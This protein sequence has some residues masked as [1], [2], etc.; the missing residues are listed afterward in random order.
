MIRIREQE[1]RL[2]TVPGKQVFGRLHIE[3]DGGERIRGECYSNHFRIVPEMSTFAGRALSLRF[4]ADVTGIPD[5]G[6]ID[7]GLTV[8]TEAGEFFIPVHVS[9]EETRLETSYGAIRTLS[10]FAEYAHSDPEEAFRLMRSD[11]FA[12]LIPEEDHALRALWRGFSKPPAAITA[13]EEFL[14]GAGL[15][16]PV[17]LRA[18]TD[19][20]EFYSLTDSS[21]ELLTIRRSGWGNFLITVETDADFIE[22]PRKR[23]TD[24]DFVGSVYD[25]AYRINAHRIGSGVR[26][27]AIRLKSAAGSFTL[28]VTASLREKEAASFE[29]PVLKNRAALLKERLL[30]MLDRED[31]R[32]Y[33]EHSLALLEERYG[34]TNENL[35]AMRLYQAY[36]QELLGK[37]E[38]AGAI[39]REFRTDGFSPEEYEE[40]TA[41]LYLTG[42]LGIAKEDSAGISKRVR[43]RYAEGDASYTMMKLLFLTNPDIGRYP[44]RKRRY[45]EELFEAGVRSPLLYAEVLRDL[46]DNDALL[47]ELTDLSLQVLLFAAKWDLMTEPLALRAAYLSDRVR[48]ASPVL[49]RILTSAYEKWQSDG[50]LTAIVKVLMKEDPGDPAHFPWY[51]RAVERNL[52]ILRLYEYYIE[53]MPESRRQVLPL[54][55]RKYFMYNSTLP[56]QGM[57]DLY[58][59]IV[60]NRYEDPD[61]YARYKERAEVFAYRSLREGRQGESFAVLYQEFVKSLPDETSE[62]TYIDCAFMRRVYTEHPDIRAVAVVHD[63]LLEDETVPLLH[64]AACVRIFTDSAQIFFVNAAGERIRSSVDYSM[65]PLMEEGR[66]RRILGGCTADHAGLRL[67]RIL[68][69]AA[70]TEDH[71]ELLRLMKEVAASPVYTDSFRDEARR[72]I[73]HLV[74]TDWN[75]RS[76]NPTEEEL[77]A[78]AAA[79]KSGLIEVLLDAGREEEAYRILLER[80]TENVGAECL[81]RLASRMIAAAEGAKD[82]E[83][84]AFSEQVFREGLYDERMLMYLSEW[85][86]GSMDEMLALRRAADSFYVD[87]FVLDDRILRRAVFSNSP[88]SEAP[89]ILRDYVRAGGRK[90]VIRSFLTFHADTSL[91]RDGKV[92]PVIVAEAA[93]ALD[94][95]E[96]IDFAVKLMLLKYY[97]EKGS[98][99]V[100]EEVQVDRLLEECEKRG[101][102]MMFMKN[103]PASFVSAY[104]LLDKVYIETRA[105]EGETV[106]L[107]YSFGDDWKTEM[108]IPKFRTLL[109]KEFTLFY[110]ETLSY[111]FIRVKEGEET[112]S[113][114]RTIR[115]GSFDVLG[116]SAFQRINR[117][118]KFRAEGDE[119]KLAEELREYLVAK[120]QSEVLFQLEDMK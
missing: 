84:T 55:V 95:G 16:E 50:I 38:E 111:T 12:E 113:D 97:S 82:E 6:A 56:E 101:I 80:G 36:L 64:G 115:C 114:V 11:R 78:Y 1:I 18:E 47:S 112:E 89:E 100:H 21:E 72:R 46:R 119:E 25:L 102:H 96:P 10:D 44:R 57:A 20:A 29:L 85:F 30:Y 86:T 83:L 34:L 15:K 54:P 9:V 53:T 61:T 63:D 37:R 65:V 69:M 118:L 94:S 110:G 106:Y 93:E 40:E 24:A 90:S 58:A 87:T 67:S 42:L 74:L 19:H 59:N 33:A 70:D 109:T 88:I 60:R 52:R 105:E 39:L 71:E 3:S 48:E 22:L 28:Q 68:S 49:I 73:L 23:I 108:L 75:L 2:V 107:R 7:G 79:D 17:V 91:G 116:L 51:E 35:T 45:E 103:L 31:R 32:S 76:F 81:V 66:A 4:G 5:G 92:D 117:M 13:M 8:V 98:L 62:N 27:G 104:R 41:Y 26:R 99:T 120:H 14:A 77:S 43:T